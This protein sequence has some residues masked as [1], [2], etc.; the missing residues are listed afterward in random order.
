MYITVLLQYN[1]QYTTVL[2]QYNIQY[3]CSTII[4]VS[5]QILLLQFSNIIHSD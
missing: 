5:V 2:L 3:T 4:I 1:I